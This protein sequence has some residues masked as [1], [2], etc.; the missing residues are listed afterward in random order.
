MP[1]ASKSE[2]WE[3]NYQAGNTRWDIGGAAPP[4]LS[5]LNSAA[6]PSP[7]RAAV[8]GCGRGYEAILLALK[9]SDLILPHQRSLS[10]PLLPPLPT[11]Q[12]NS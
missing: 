2:F 12:P 8:L 9:Q 1:S 11:C 4:F 5:L 10:P 6:A 3:Q 7:G